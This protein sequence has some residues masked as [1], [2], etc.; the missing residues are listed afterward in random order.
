MA[1]RDADK[2]VVQVGDKVVTG[3]GTGFIVGAGSRYD[4]IEVV[5][6]GREGTTLMKP[7]SVWVVL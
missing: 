6:D 2:E 7:E 1:L 5:L 3:Q 4:L